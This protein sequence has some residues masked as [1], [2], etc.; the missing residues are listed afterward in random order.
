MKTTQ[1]STG[2]N[3]CISAATAEKHAA[4]S[5]ELPHDHT[6]PLL[7]IYAKVMKSYKG[8]WPPR[9]GA[10]LFTVVRVLEPTFL[11]RDKWIKATDRNVRSNTQ[12]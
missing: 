9:L 7:S 1:V 3:V 8:V 10:A 2:G 5:K 4:S 12:S 6:V 11:S